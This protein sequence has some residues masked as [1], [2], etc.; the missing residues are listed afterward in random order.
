MHGVV[1]VSTVGLLLL[2]EPT[3]VLHAIPEPGKLSFPNLSL[4]TTC[5]PLTRLKLRPL[6]KKA[7]AFSTHSPE[8]LTEYGIFLLCTYILIIDPGISVTS[9]CPREADGGGK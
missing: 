3:A 1:S 6:A 9:N 4:V 8:S 2:T 7:M 5:D